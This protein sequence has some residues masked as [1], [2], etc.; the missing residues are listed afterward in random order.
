MAR[1]SN[2][3]IQIVNFLALLVSLAILGF[4][5]FLATR[6]GDCEKL[7]DVPVLV[8]GGFILIISLVALI[9]SLK[10]IPILLWIYLILMFFVLVGIAAFTV[11]FFVVTHDGGGHAV[12]GRGYKEYKLGDYSHWLQ[13]KLNNS[14]DWKHLKSC[15]VKTKYCSDLIKD[16]KTLKAYEKADLTPIQSGCCKP[17]SECGYSAKNA[18][19]YDLSVQSR[20]TNGD[21]KL[22]KNSPSIRCY[23]CASCKAGVAQYLKEKWKVVAIVDSIAFAL[24]ILLYCVGCCA[25]RNATDESYDKMSD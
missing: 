18:S 22:Y 23:N 13:K 1:L 15:L 12:S 2:G 6:H 3:V 24:L 14:N 25:K 19:Y 4:G 10:D 5:A 9:G 17:P 7:L 20:S 16:Y 8:L 11:F 21:C